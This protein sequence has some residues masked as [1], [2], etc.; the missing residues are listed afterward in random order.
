ME[1]L[2]LDDCL[3]MISW[4]MPKRT[5]RD[6]NEARLPQDV[7]HVESQSILVGNINTIYSRAEMTCTLRVRICFVNLVYI[8]VN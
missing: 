7:C 8:L 6:E 3:E 5:S 1:M 2:K 4:E